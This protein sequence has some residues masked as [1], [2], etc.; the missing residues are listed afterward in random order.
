MPI[1]DHFNPSVCDLCDSPDYSVLVDL[2]TN[3]AMRS[4]RRI[5][6]QNLVK[7]ECRECGLARSGDR[8]TAGELNRYYLQDY[9]VSVQPEHYFYTTEGPISRSR[10]LS[11]WMRAALDSGRLTG[12]HRCLEIGAGSG[13]LIQ[14]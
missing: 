9:G 8:I 5:V 3:R 7:L 13:L 4:D 11:E 12:L 1:S 10:L 6:A 14:E 2:K